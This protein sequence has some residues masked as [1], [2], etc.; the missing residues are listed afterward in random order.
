MAEKQKRWVQAPAATLRG[1]PLIYTGVLL[2]PDEDVRWSWTHTP[3]G[4]YVSGFQITK[5]EPDDSV[6]QTGSAGQA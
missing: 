6:S 4:S 2:E 1:A 3:K 5:R